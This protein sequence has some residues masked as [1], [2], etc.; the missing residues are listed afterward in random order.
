M[1][2]CE[3]AGIREFV[4]W[5]CMIDD[6]SLQGMLIN[7]LIRMD[8]CQKLLSEGNESH[9]ELLKNSLLFDKHLLLLVF[10]SAAVKACSASRVITNIKCIRKMGMIALIDYCTFLE[11]G[12]FCQRVILYSD[13][14]RFWLLIPLY[15]WWLITH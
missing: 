3:R 15:N 9:V 14:I 5:M 11:H 1:N 7:R 10:S 13:K 12:C 6:C 2:Q 4:F 8:W